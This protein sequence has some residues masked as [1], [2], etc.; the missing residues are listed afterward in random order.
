MNLL[1]KMQHLALISIL[2][3]SDGWINPTIKFPDLLYNIFIFNILT[4]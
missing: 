4:C 1:L 3:K 2:A